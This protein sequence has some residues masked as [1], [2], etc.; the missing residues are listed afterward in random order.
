MSL[1]RGLLY[2]H[3]S[4][5]IWTFPFLYKLHHKSSTATTAMQRALLVPRQQITLDGKHLARHPCRKPIHLSRILLHL[6]TVQ[7]NVQPTR[8]RGQLEQARP[9]I[10]GQQRLLRCSAR[11]V[12]RLALRLPLRNLCLLARQR[13]LVVLVVVELGVVRFDALKQQIAGLFE[14]RV[15]GEVEA[16][17][18]WVEREFLG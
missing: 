18:V 2:D 14:E 6:P 17:E 9:L 8:L 1:Q 16:V 13:S 7:Q 15:D 5:A 4:F 10:L 11:R 12:L 3:T